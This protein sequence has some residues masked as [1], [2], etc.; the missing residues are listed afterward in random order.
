M[1]KLNW[2]KAAKQTRM[3]RQGVIRALPEEVQ[4]AWDKKARLA[5]KAR[6]ARL[7]Q[8]AREQKRLRRKARA[9]STQ[10]AAP[11][12]PLRALASCPQCGCQ[13]LVAR[14]EQHRWRVH[15]FKP[16]SKMSG[17]TDNGRSPVSRIIL[18]GR[19]AAR[20]LPVPQPS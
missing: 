15:F 2:N 10:A 11:P 14:L 9:A 18:T 13:V 6:E 16:A 20:V 7:A 17:P 12:R 3:A 4:R 8:E 19:G 1:A 5:K